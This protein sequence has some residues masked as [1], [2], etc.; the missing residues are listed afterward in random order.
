MN[1]AHPVIPSQLTSSTLGSSQFQVKFS[2]FL[3]FL[4]ILNSGGG[5]ECFCLLVLYQ[6]DAFCLR[7]RDLLNRFA[8]EVSQHQKH[9]QSKEHA[10]ILVRVLCLFIQIILFPS[11]PS[12]I[13]LS[14]LK[15]ELSASRR[16]W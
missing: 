9:G 16:S 6:M 15:T 11:P 4:F 12:Y 3:T 14:F 5:Y 2:L 7:E 8:M 10:F 13:V 1:G